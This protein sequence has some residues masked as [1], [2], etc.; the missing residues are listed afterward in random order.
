MMR[1]RRRDEIVWFVK[2]PNLLLEYITKD[3]NICIYLWACCLHTRKQSTSG[4]V[5]SS[6]HFPE[7][8]LKWRLNTRQFSSCCMHRRAAQA[9]WQ[10]AGPG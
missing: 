10:G 7:L 6:T 5:A 1:V 8:P 3:N 2:H 9:V 4:T